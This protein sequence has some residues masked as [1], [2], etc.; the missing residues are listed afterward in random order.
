MRRKTA[1]I[2]E[3][4]RMIHANFNHLLQKTAKYQSKASGLTC[5]VSGLSYLHG[6]DQSRVDLLQVA[7]I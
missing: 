1:I 5:A 7:L 4:A 6:L 2:T 3:N